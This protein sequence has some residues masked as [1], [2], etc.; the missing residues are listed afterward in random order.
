VHNSCYQCLTLLSLRNTA[1]QQRVREEAEAE[2]KRTITAG[3]ASSS[4]KGLPQRVMDLDHR[5]SGWF[6]GKDGAKTK[7]IAAEMR[8][9]PGPH[10]RAAQLL[11]VV[12]N[13]WCDGS[14]MPDDAPR[15]LCLY[16]SAQQAARGEELVMAALSNCPEREACPPRPRSGKQDRYKH[17][18]IV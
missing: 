2:R 1:A 8:R 14:V 7:A 15:R 10:G 16:G 11:V 6:I 17:I 3:P 18:N 12:D 9:L 5:I 13:N 4:N